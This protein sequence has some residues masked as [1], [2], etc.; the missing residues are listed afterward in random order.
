MLEI[1][2]FSK[3]VVANW[4]LNGS[5]E[6][7]HD[8]FKV[9]DSDNFLD[10]LVCGVICPPTIYLQECSSINTYL[11]TGAQD[12]SNYNN[13]AFT[14][15]NSAK[16]IKDI[17]CDFCIIGHSERRQIFNEKNEIIRVKAQNLIENDIVPIVCVG[18]TLDEKNKGKTK[19][20][21]YDQ[22]SNS[23]P[24]NL[25]N[26]TVILAYEPIWAIGTGLTATLQEIQTIHK[27]IKNEIKN[28][29]NFKVLYG[30]SVK[31]ENS[32]DIM[33][34]ESVDW[35]LVGGASLKPDDFIKILK[36]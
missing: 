23:I 17:K 34:L 13:G 10:P 36:S 18:E 33:N 11:F 30:G 31:S 12:C 2:N 28:F 32:K 16:M 9:F 5:K 1:N 7:V 26:N 19:E 24:S 4:K 27:F 8:F 35:V 15:E 3:I 21:L 29:E 25:S 14:G 22:I 20:V 6:F